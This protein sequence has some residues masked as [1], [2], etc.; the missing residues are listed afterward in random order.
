MARPSEVVDLGVA[1]VVAIADWL[2]E[3]GS[4][5]HDSPL[6]IALASAHSGH[7]RK[8]R[9][10]LQDGCPSQRKGWYQKTDVP[11]PHPTLSYHGGTGRNRRRCAEGS[12]TQQAQEFEYAHDI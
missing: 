8:R 2:E 12:K 3:R 4:C 7:R 1:T 10:Y 6:F 11:S 5:P 9:R